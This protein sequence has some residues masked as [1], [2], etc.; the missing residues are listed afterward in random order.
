VI[1][2]R[3]GLGKDSTTAK[4][5]EG[6][7]ARAIRHSF[8]KY[9]FIEKSAER[10]AELE[11]L[12]ANSDVRDRISIHHGDANQKL[13]DFAQSTDWKTHRAV[14]FLDPY[15]M[16]VEWETIQA[17]GGTNAVDLWFLF[18][19]GQAVMRLLLKGAEPPPEWRSRLDKIFGTSHGKRSFTSRQLKAIFFK[20][21]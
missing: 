10:V 6:S 2:Q 11:K 20:V 15:G 8:H 5:L 21:R 9:L 16:Q 13:L 4:L 7:A 17:L 1:Q 14:V 12:R 19:L 18:P 3:S